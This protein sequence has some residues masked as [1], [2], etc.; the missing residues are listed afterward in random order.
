MKADDPID[1]K[2]LKEWADHC[3]D[4][5]IDASLKYREEISRQDN[6][7]RGRLAQRR[8]AVEAAIH[9]YVK[10]QEELRRRSR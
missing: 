10:A 1:W 2:F 9:E 5:I 8:S 3:F 7:H 4:S 6:A